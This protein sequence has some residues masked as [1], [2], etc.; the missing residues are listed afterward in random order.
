[1]VDKA[2]IQYDLGIFIRDQIR[3]DT[4]DNNILS[5]NSSVDPENWIFFGRPRDME[6]TLDVP[7]IIV[8]PVDEIREGYSLDNLK[9]IYIPYTIHIW[10]D[11][12]VAESYDIYK[13]AD[14]IKVL[15]EGWEDSEGIYISEVGGCPILQE[16]H[17]S[18]VLLHAAVKNDIT[19]RE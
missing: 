17:E 13:I 19:W 16:N 12:G 9:E 3:E 8:E 7:R 10:L 14:R 2:T 1:M 11:Q 5:F 18:K 15:I 4:G 6:K